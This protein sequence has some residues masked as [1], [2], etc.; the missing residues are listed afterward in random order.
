MLLRSPN[1]APLTRLRLHF[2][3][4][5]FALGPQQRVLF[6]CP[7]QALL[8]ADICAAVVDRFIDADDARVALQT[9]DG[10]LVPSHESVSILRDNDELVVVRCETKS[11][12]QKRKHRGIVNP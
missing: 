4:S 9:P 8:V 5:D 12:K 3:E 7:A 6:L 11:K 1:T 10:F 2:N